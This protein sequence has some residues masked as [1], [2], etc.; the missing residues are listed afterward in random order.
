LAAAG[1]AKAVIDQ[2]CRLVPT[3]RPAEREYE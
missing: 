1:D 3:Y 2:L